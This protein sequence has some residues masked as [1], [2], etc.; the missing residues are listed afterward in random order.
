ML[1]CDETMTPIVMATSVSDVGNVRLGGGYRLP[2]S[3]AEVDKSIG[4]NNRLPVSISDRGVVRLGGGYR[5]PV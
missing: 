4:K 2:L 1:F 3:I 5:L